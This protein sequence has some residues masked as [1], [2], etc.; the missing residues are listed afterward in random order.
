MSIAS[1]ALA[2]AAALLL[3]AACA[4]GKPYPDS[5]APK[6]LTLRTASTAR[7][8]LGVHSVDAQCRAEYLGT[9][10]LDKPS[11]EIGIPAEQWSYLVFDFATS[12]FLAAKR[13]RTT[14]ETLFKPRAGY[15]YEANVTYRDDIYNVVIREQ[16]H[17]GAW[18][19]VAFRDLATCKN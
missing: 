18:R 4:G 10:G 13:T 11:A 15:R 9:V 14:L 12:S 3:L 7:A 16:S 8:A 5:V 19:E 17:R 6:N 2:R 1:G